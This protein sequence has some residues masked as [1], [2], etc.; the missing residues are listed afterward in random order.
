MSEITPTVFRSRLD[1]ISYI[2][3]NGKVVT[4]ADRKYET[5]DQDE[6]DHLT[7]EAQSPLNP[8]FYIGDP[9]MV[10]ETNTGRVIQGVVAESGDEEIIEDTSAEPA[11]IDESS[12]TGILSTDNSTE[13]DAEQSN[14]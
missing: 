6:I 11:R 10:V 8:T 12:S 9:E 2:F 4:F 14:S 5:I 3:P 13:Q 7:K 1:G